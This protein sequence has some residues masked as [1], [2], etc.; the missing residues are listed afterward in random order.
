MD[1][2]E[3]Q[4]VKPLDKGEVDGLR[5]WLRTCAIPFAEMDGKVVLSWEAVGLLRE[6]VDLIREA[7]EYLSG[8]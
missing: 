6:R 4:H 2:S 1:E 8:E 5:Q 3:K 7:M